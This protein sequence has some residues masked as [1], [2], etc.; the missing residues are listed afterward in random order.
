MP[1]THVGA[2]GDDCP[3]AVVYNLPSTAEQAVWVGWMRSV[4][5][6]FWVETYS[7]RTLSS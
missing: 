1:H 7:S 3:Y 6:Q 4:T 5:R 2:I